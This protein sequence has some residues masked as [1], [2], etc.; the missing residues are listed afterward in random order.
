MYTFIANWSY[1]P[2]FIT[3]E[4]LTSPILKTLTIGENLLSKSAVEIF[5]NHRFFHFMKGKNTK[6]STLG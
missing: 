4:L 5:Q 2:E 1:S 3:E 6:I